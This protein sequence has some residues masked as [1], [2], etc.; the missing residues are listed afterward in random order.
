MARPILVAGAAGRVGAVGRTV[1][2][3]L[4]GQ[5]PDCACDGAERRRG[6]LGIAPPGRGGRAGRS[7][8]SWSSSGSTR[9]H[10]RVGEG[11]DS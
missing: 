8:R 7:A 3:L 11:S 5:G 10:S 1:T 2:E 9:R 4:L 6:R